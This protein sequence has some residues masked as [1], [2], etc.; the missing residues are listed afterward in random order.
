MGNVWVTNKLGSSEYGR[1]KQLEIL[2]AMKINF[3][4]DPDALNRA[5]KV[6]VPALA[7]QKPGWDGGSIAVFRPDGTEAPFSPVY[8]KGIYAPWAAC[9]R[10]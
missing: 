3:D 10:Q 5:G 1:V 6:L 2:A 9:R 4:N 7:A 8:G